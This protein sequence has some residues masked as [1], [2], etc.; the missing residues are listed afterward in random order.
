M[1]MVCNGNNIPNRRVECR[2]TEDLPFRLE[3]AP[4]DSVSVRPPPVWARD[5]QKDEAWNK[6]DAV[7]AEKI[8]KLHLPQHPPVV[9]AVEGK[10]N[11]DGHG[12]GP[13]CIALHKTVKGEQ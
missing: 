8:R 3:P 13:I 6:G 12:Q 10:V 4:Q 9:L 11:V 1:P 7:A 5:P 2:K